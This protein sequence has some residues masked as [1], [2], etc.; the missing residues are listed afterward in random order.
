[1]RKRSFRPE[2]SGLE[3]RQLLSTVVNPKAIMGSP[4]AIVGA[5]PAEPSP[6]AISAP[7]VTTFGDTSNA[8]PA[9]V[10]FHGKTFMAWS[11]STNGS[12]NLAVVV[13]GQNGY[14][15][16][17][18]VTLSNYLSPG[19][20]PA[21]AVF[22]GRAYMAWTG[23][24]GQ[25]NVV[26]TAD[27]V[28]IEKVTLADTSRTGPALAA[29][30]GR[31]YL[32]WTGLD[33]RLNVESSADGM[34]LGNKVTLPETSYI[35]SGKQ[36]VELSPAL[37]SF[38]GRLYIAWTGTNMHLNVESSADGMRF[39]NKVT[40]G[41]TS[42]AAPALAVEMPA[43][44]GQPTRL[45]L[46]WTGVGNAEINTMTSTDGR[47]FG[48]KVTSKQ[49]GFGGLALLSPSAG[50]LDIAWDGFQTPPRHLNL[51]QV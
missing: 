47:T 8:A 42:D 38:G 37:A 33:G 12:L 41:E 7:A 40:L 31:L 29:F 48:G 51:M 26:S 5:P 34:T 3:G 49:T 46:G 24:D 44:Q 4:P 18:K 15:L 45:V 32:G 20:S 11:G 1:M 13:R 6:K 19:R 28:H 14:Q 25:L 21:L 30:N 27:G 43:V 17:S 16:E 39:G 10:E 36:V 9:L 50:T 35:V 23:T 2:I 22:N